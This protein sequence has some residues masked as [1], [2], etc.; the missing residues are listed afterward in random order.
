MHSVHY[1]RGSSFMFASRAELLEDVR[2]KYPDAVI[3]WDLEEEHC[4]GYS[5]A[6]V[7]ADRVMTL[8]LHMSL[9]GSF[10]EPCGSIFHPAVATILSTKPEVEWLHLMS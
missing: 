6:V 9:C 8:R 10:L 7:F 4:D 1:A 2:T 5:H 3:C